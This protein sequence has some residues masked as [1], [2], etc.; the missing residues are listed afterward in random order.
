MI[1]ER[2]FD[3]LIEDAREIINTTYPEWRLGQCIFNLLAMNYPATADL[4]RG[5]EL[6]MYYNNDRIIKFKNK[7]NELKL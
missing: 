2:Q 4:I 1:T 3:E 5:T 7:L 6:D